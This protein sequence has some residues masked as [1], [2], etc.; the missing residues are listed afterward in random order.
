[1][2]RPLLTL[3][4]LTALSIP[5]SNAELPEIDTAPYCMEKAHRWV[6]RGVDWENDFWRCM[7]TEF[8]RVRDVRWRLGMVSQ[9]LQ[10]RCIEKGLEKGSYSAIDHCLDQV[11]VPLRR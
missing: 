4:L 11:S 6:R 3:I 1:M 2:R 5:S 7:Q 9:D 8:L 10:E